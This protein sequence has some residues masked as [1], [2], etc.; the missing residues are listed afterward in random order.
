MQLEEAKSRTKETTSW[1]K[2]QLEMT[3]AELM[4]DLQYQQEVNQKKIEAMALEKKKV[5]D[6]M[7]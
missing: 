7:N 2:S 1:M 4:K 6:E 5:L 3:W